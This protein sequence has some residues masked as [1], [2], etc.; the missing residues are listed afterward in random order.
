MDSSTTV[1]DKMS[2]AQLTILILLLIERIAKFFVN[3]KCYKHLQ[4]NLFGMKVIDLNSEEQDVDKPP[5]S[6][7]NI[8]K[9]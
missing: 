9:E 7:R 5:Q 4:L 2:S 8:N 3:S 6:P 1:Y